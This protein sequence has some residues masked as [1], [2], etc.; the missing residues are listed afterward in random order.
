M[1]VPVCDQVPPPLIEN[2]TAPCADE[3]VMV[4]VPSVTPQ[5]VMLVEATLAITGATLS[6]N[7]TVLPVTWQVPF[8]LRTAML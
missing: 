5:F 2:S 1:N 6:V 3:A 4:I 7:T 8:A